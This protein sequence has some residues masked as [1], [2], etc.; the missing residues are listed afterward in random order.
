MWGRWL[1]FVMPEIKMKGDINEKHKLLSEFV[2]LCSSCSVGE[3]H[4][5]RRGRA[6]L[7][8]REVDHHLPIKYDQKLFV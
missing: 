8:D 1:S 2:N 7:G 3:R 4:E 5:A 6:D